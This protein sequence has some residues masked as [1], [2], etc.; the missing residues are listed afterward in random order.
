MM[1]QVKDKERLIAHPYLEEQYDIL[2]GSSRNQPS[3]TNGKTWA[4]RA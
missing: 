2:S 3:L 1:N 4:Q